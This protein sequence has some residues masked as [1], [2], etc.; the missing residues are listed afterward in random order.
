MIKKVL[1]KII[2]FLD[3]HRLILVLL[4][5]LLI[6]FLF[7]GINSLLFLYHNFKPLECDKKIEDNYCYHENIKIFVEPEEEKNNF[8]KNNSKEIKILKETYNLPDFS[9]HTAYFYSLASELEYNMNEENNKLYDFF[10]T[11]KNT[12]DLEKFYKKNIFYYEIFYD[13]KIF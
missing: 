9:Y 11:Y 2:N 8:F 13:Y 12:Y 10:A 6:S 1:K 5:L 3:R 7:L 4:I